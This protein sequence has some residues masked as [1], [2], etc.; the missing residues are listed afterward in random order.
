MLMLSACLSQG[1]PPVKSACACA[2]LALAYIGEEA[3][4]S[5]LACRRAAL[6]YFNAAQRHVY[7]SS[8]AIAVLYAATVAVEE[9]DM[10]VFFSLG[11]VPL[12]L[13]D[14]L[15]SADALTFPALQRV[16]QDWPLGKDAA[17]TEEPW[18]IALRSSIVEAVQAMAVAG[19]F[20][21]T[22]QRELQCAVSTPWW[23]S[24]T[25][26]AALTDTG[27]AY[28]VLFFCLGIAFSTRSD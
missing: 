22:G 9:Q 19:R 23:A 27:V 28:G 10:R 20:Y 5:H 17:A 6:L 21:M 14:Q 3:R 11:R 15:S 12:P 25:G 8:A 16:L 26:V 24:L 2:I 18:E 13:L 1:L 4:R 7:K